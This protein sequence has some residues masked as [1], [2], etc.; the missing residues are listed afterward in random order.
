MHQ[1]GERLGRL[2]HLV[3]DVDW[4]TL[5]LSAYVR[6]TIAELDECVSQGL[7]LAITLLPEQWSLDVVPA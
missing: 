3:A 4:P 1:T 7:V 5:R 2:G 6:P